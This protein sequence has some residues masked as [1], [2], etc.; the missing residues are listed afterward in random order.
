MNI[1][2]KNATLLPEYGY[3]SRTVNVLIKDRKIAEIT[4]KMPETTAEQVIDCQG[5]LLLP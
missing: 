1:L 3:D 5:N 2:L 4:E